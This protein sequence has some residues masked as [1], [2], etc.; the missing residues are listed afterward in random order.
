[1]A[2][3]TLIT[4]T[5]L[6]GGSVYALKFDQFEDK[7]ESLTLN[8]ILNKMKVFGSDDD[9]KDFTLNE[10]IKISLLIVSLYDHL[11]RKGMIAWNNSENEL[12][13]HYDPTEEWDIDNEEPDDWFLHI[14]PRFIDRA[15][16]DIAD[17]LKDTLD[18]SGRFW[19]AYALEIKYFDKDVFLQHVN[20][21]KYLYNY[22][23]RYIK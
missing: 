20:Y 16:M 5:N 23:K 3:T 9:P 4:K 21:I 8:Q 14:S 6:I 10:R 12:L 2:T 13:N 15:M 22:L 1:M 18:Q 11:E 17:Q 7:F 19:R